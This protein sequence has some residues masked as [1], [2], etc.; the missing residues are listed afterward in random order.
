MKNVTFH[1]AIHFGG[2]TEYW[3]SSA[4]ADD[5]AVG[6]IENAQPFDSEEDANSYIIET[7]L[8]FAEA[9]GW[10]VSFSVEAADWNE[11]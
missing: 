7:C 6:L 4:I 9:K 10:E 5:C 11:E 3:N 2:N 1:I 8:P